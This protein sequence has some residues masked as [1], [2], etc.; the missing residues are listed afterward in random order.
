M[1]EEKGKLL[2]IQLKDTTD[3]TVTED[4]TA[5]MVNRE[6]LEDMEVSETDG[7]EAITTSTR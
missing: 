7:E 6:D 2:P 3:I 5:T 1:S 4:T